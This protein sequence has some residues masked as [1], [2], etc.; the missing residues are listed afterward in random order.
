MTDAWIAPPRLLALICCAL[1]ELLHPSVDALF[2]LVCV[3]HPPL[4]PY[5]ADDSF[6]TS[7]VGILGCVRFKMNE[8]TSISLQFITQTCYRCSIL[9][10]DVSA[11]K[12][13]LPKV[14]RFD[15]QGLSYFCLEVYRNEVSTFNVSSSLDSQF[16]S[17]YMSRRL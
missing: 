4:Y 9:R 6:M 12:T 8:L 11:I 14:D 5:C 17:G 16:S 2:V 7:T 15:F 13:S 10:N 3:F 1:K